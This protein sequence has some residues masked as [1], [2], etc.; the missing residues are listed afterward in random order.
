MMDFAAARANMVESQ[1]RTGGTTDHRVLAAFG[2]VPR[3]LFVP[4][5]RRSIAYVVDDLLIK[6]VNGSHS[7]RFLMEPMVLARLIDLAEVRAG[8]K[9]LHVG[10]GTGYATA[11]L[12]RLARQVVAIDEDG[13]LVAQARSLLAS[14]GVSN[15]RILEESHAQGAPAEAPFDVILVEGRIPAVSPGLIAQI[16]QDGRLVAVVGERAVAT[17]TLFTRHGEA[18]S[19]RPAFEAAA[20]R[21]PGFVIE[22]PAFVF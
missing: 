12:A 2:A 10:C 20:R 13:Q 19:A 16:G 9:V 3:E 21:L 17:A 18:T 7:A 5:E 15:A 8:D 22:R 4:S 6:P 11:I 14:L 1:I